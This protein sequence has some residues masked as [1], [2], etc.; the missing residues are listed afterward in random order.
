MNPVRNRERALL[1]TYRADLIHH[2]KIEFD[3][4][5]FAFYF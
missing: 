1:E 5:S 3:D 2:S 4:M